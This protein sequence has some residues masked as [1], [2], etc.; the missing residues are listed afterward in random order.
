MHVV[1]RVA[2][3][4]GTRNANAFDSTGVRGS[5]FRP[6]AVPASPPTQKGVNRD[7][8]PLIM[9]S[10]PTWNDKATYP[11]LSRSVLSAPVVV[12]RPTKRSA[13]RRTLQ[14]Q[15]CND[16]D[17]SPSTSPVGGSSRGSSLPV[18]GD[19]RNLTVGVR[20]GRGCL[21][22]T[23]L[24][25]ATR[26][27]PWLVPLT[28]LVFGLLYSSAFTWLRW[29]GLCPPLKRLEAMTPATRDLLRNAGTTLAHSTVRLQAGRG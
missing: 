24:L 23:V 21:V 15:S 14:A 11:L 5:Q 22:L 3:T 6:T 25:L 4:K 1:V 27:P 12:T 8:R 2:S 13:P 7:P 17:S 26:W 28:S 20:F 19:L 16:N 10:G 18:S 9:L 29:I